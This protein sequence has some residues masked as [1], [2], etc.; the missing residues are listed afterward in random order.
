MELLQSLKA[1]VTPSLAKNLS[2]GQNLSISIEGVA[3]IHIYIY[4]YI[5]IYIYI[6]FIYTMQSLIVSKSTSSLQLELGEHVECGS[7]KY[8]WGG[9]FYCNHHL[10]GNCKDVTLMGQ[11]HVVQFNLCMIPRLALIGARA[12]PCILLLTCQTRRF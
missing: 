12:L 2:S 11:K 7:R 5:Y 10:E 8:S 6:L 9:V 3:Y 4:M 1:F